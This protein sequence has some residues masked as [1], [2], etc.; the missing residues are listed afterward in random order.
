MDGLIN[1]HSQLL[2]LLCSSLWVP[3]KFRNK[4]IGT[5]IKFDFKSACGEVCGEVWGV[6]IL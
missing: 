4:E 5:G 1:V 6:M 2:S 3:E